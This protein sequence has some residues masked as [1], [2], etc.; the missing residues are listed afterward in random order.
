MKK[1]TIKLVLTGLF[2]MFI[3]SFIP[4]IMWILFNDGTRPVDVR[5]GMV[6]IGGIVTV[7]FTI[8]LYS[9]LINKLIISRVKK[10]NEATQ[11]VIR[12]DF[13]AQLHDPLRD[14]VS[15]L[16]NNFSKMLEE[17]K[18]NEYLSK[19]F[20][21][22]FSHEL[23]TPLAA[24]QG[25]AELLH[26]NNLSDQERDEYTSIIVE[27]T[28]RLSSL[29]TNMLLIS[30][31]D[32]TKIVPKQDEY[33]IAEQ[34]RNVLQ[35]MQLD[36][37]RKRLEFDINMKDTTI[38]SNKEL[39]YQIFTNLINNA[40]KFTEEGKTISIT[41]DKKDDLI[42]L[43]VS[44]PGYLGQ[45]DLEQIFE[46]FY[47]KDKTRKGNSSGVGLALTKKILQKLGGSIDVYSQN[48]EIQFKITIPTN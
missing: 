14:E 18:N 44:N 2:V 42:H 33:N 15:E 5:P 48:N 28:K 39:T 38:L 34:I 8:L 30:Q 41:M 13:E 24:I 43:S 35:L 7:S 1:L 10:L 37:E 4:N 23:K 19:E 3:A 6:L 29:S 21:R 26:T 16:T 9:T 22:N 45:K 27:E 36:W 46:P 31:I 40:I 20:V 17:L 25:Y 47:M 12:G 11:D 32:S